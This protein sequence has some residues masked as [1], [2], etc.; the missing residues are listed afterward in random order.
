MQ[1]A[2]IEAFEHQEIVYRW[3][4]MLSAQ[5]HRIDFFVGEELYHDCPARLRTGA[6]GW[7]VRPSARSWP[8]YLHDQARQ[9]AAYDAIVLLTTG[10]EYDWFLPLPPTVPIVL[11]VHSPN[12]LVD[13]PQ[14]LPRPKAW[15]A[16]L[17]RGRAGARRRLLQRIAAIASPTPTLQAALATLNKKHI[18]LPYSYSAANWPLPAAGNRLTITI[19]G[20]VQ[21]NGRDYLLL[22]RALSRCRKPPGLQLAVVLLG[23]VKDDGLL[24][25]MRVLTD[26]AGIELSAFAAPVP[27]AD[28]ERIMSSSQFVIVPLR[29]YYYYGPFREE[30]ARISGALDDMVYYGRPGLLPH[31]YELTEPQAALAQTYTD[32]DDLVAKLEDWIWNASYKRQYE[33]ACPVLRQ[34]DQ[35]AV[36]RAWLQ[37]IEQVL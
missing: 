11:C 4:D 34:H 23:R 14:W 13:K 29:P 33:A 37:A 9:L 24:K 30:N 3:A 28:F 21:R 8:D 17:L 1:I 36:G 32:E 7:N 20:T 16:Y 35:A 18:L 5:P 6:I 27:A 22:A 19:P 25:Q 10:L 31:F 12:A 2:I 15:L 26:R